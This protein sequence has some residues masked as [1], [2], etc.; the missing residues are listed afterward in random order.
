M[1]FFCKSTWYSHFVSCFLGGYLVS[2][3]MQYKKKKHKR[4]KQWWKLSKFSNSLSLNNELMQMSDTAQ[5]SSF[6][7]II[8]TVCSFALRLSL[9]GS[10]LAFEF[11]IHSFIRTTWAALITALIVRYY[12]QHGPQTKWVLRSSRKALPLGG[13]RQR[14]LHLEE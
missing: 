5:N 14:L 11:R 3:Y 8:S 4:G 1:P 2:F 13:N 6:P 10:W 12:H 9:W 7:S